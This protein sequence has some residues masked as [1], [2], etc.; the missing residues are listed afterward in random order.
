MMVLS[1]KDRGY[2]AKTG[3]GRELQVYTMVRVGLVEK[4]TS[5]PEG[6]SIRHENM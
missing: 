3:R 5:E 6:D 4:V 2:P 1:E